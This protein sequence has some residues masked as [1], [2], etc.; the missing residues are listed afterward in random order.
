M[1]V[2]LCWTGVSL[3]LSLTLSLFG[4]FLCLFSLSRVCCL[5]NE[6]CT[7][8][9]NPRQAAGLGTYNTQAN[10]HSL[11]PSPSLPPALHWM[12]GWVAMFAILTSLRYL[13]N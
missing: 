10:T 9:K 11:T 3:S 1:F 8:I 13:T 7:A 2:C 5:I 6:P 12:D 4:L